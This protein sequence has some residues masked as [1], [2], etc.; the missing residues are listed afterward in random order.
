MRR[1]LER[2]RLPLQPG[3]PWSWSFNY[4]TWYHTPLVRQE[5]APSDHWCACADA[6][7]DEGGTVQDRLVEI[8]VCRCC[9]HSWIM[10]FTFA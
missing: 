7:L 8:I 2:P 9:S 3:L 5:L 6:K 4:G 10:L 1:D